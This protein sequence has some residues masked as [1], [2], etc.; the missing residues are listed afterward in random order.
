MYIKKRIVSLIFWAG[1]LFFFAGSANAQVKYLGELGILGGGSYYNGDANSRK[2]FKDT[3]LAFGG[4][5]RAHV[6]NRFMI[7][8]SVIKG[9]A[10]G[11]TRDFKN[12]LPNGQQ[13]DFSQNFWDIGIHFE[14][15]FC[16][17][18]M[19]SWDRE[20][21]RHT[22]YILVGPGLSIYEHWSG[23]KHTFNFTFGVGYKFKL[24]ER[25][26]VGVEWSMRKLFVDDFDVTKPSNKILDDPY[27][28]GHSWIKNNDY[29]TCAF[30]FISFDLLK[31]KG[32]CRT[33]QF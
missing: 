1:I 7:K 26:N 33:L 31:R 10:S 25:C 20:L 19:E 24:S 8:V 28:A 32:A 15:N 29:Y 12:L 4:L 6:T 22:P 14:H 3:H 11:D 5:L 27:N 18:G 2:I 16:K 30:V 17:F 21:R 23:N 13:A 9:G